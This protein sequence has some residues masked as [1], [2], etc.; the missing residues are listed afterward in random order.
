MPLT[1]LQHNQIRPVLCIIAMIVL[2]GAMVAQR[3]V[4]ESDPL[5]MRVRVVYD[6]LGAFVGPSFN[7]QGGTF[8]TNC[9]CT[10]TGGAGTGFTGGLMYEYFSRTTLSWGVSLAYDN[11]SIESRFQEREGLEQQSPT[12]GRTYTVPV[13]FRHIGESSLQYL[14]LTPYMKYSF[15][16]TLMVRVGPAFSYI[17]DANI[18]HTKELVSE[19]VPL[20]GGE[21]ATVRLP[22]QQ[23]NSMVLE[24]GAIPDL[25]PLQVS[26]SAAVGVEFRP[27]KKLFL[28]PL[29]QYIQ[30][31]TT[32]SDRGDA[33]TVRALQLQLEA[34]F[35]L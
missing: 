2:H 28:T 29:L 19:T 27:T 1:R 22:G 9:N 18:R 33:F 14:T 21:I 26:I 3:N 35:I 24:N 16:K 31:V 12:S 25:N 17:I 34:R 4:L 6:Q 10:F 8:T 13:T 7:S 23:G 30:P 5:R 15:F 11:R 32:I 20:P